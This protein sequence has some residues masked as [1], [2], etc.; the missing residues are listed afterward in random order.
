M[1]QQTKKV[2]LVIQTRD[3]RYEDIEGRCYEYPGRIQYGRQIGVGDI[4]IVSRPTKVAPDGRRIVGIGR[5][6][7]IVDGPEGRKVA[8]YDRYLAID[9]PASFDDIGGEPRQNQFITINPV[10]PAIV[11]SLLKLRGVESVDAM[12]AVAA[13]VK[14]KGAPSEYQLREELHEAVVT[15]LLGPAGGPEEEIL[16]S[17]VRDRYLV[18]KL[19]PRDGEML[20][21]EQDEMS[22][23]SD[24]GAD[25]GAAEQGAL[26]AESL[27]PA[28]FGMTFCVDSAAKEMKLLASWGHYRKT[29]S[30]V[31]LTEA[32]KPRKVWGRTPAGGEVI[33]PLTPGA[34]GPLQPDPERPEVVVQGVVRAPTP[35]D[36]VIVTAFLMNGQ[37]TPETNQDEAWL[38]Q[39]EL[40]ASA[41][42]ESPIFRRRPSGESASNDAELAALAMLYRDHV[43]FAVGHGVSIYSELAEGRRDRAVSIRTRAIPSYDVPMTEA[44]DVRDVPGFAKLE[45]DMKALA[46]L[47]KASLLRTLGVLAKEY[48][49]WIGVQAKRIEAGEVVG[50][51]HPAKEALDR[52][53]QTRS[54]LEAGIKALEQEATALDAFRFANKAMWKQRVHSIYALNRRRGKDVQL[55]DVDVPQ[56]RSWRPFQ[57]AFILLAI[58]SLTDPSHS[59]RTDIGSAVADLL[60]F[61][62]GGGKTEAYLGVAAYAMAIRRLQGVVNGLDGTRGLAVIMRYTLRLLTIQQFQRASTLLCAME[63]LRREALAAGEPRWGVT[64]FRLGL[65][66][67]QRATPNRTEDARQAIENAH[68]DAWR[69]TGSGTPAQ[70]TSCPWCG[71]EIRPGRDIK[72]R[73]FKGGVGRTLLFCSDSYGR[74]AFTPAQVPDEGLPVV[75]VDEEIYRLLPAMLI[76]TV[77]KFAQMPWKG[78]VQTLFGRVSGYCARHGFLSPDS[79]DTG[80]HNAAGQLPRTRR[81]DAPMLRPP[82][83]VIQDELHLISG[84][85]GTMVGL[86]ETAVDELATWE[87]QGKKVR[88]KVIASTATVRKA[89]EQV[90]NV[91]LRR[92]EVFPPPGLDAADN[93]FARQRPLSAEKFGRRYLGICAP[94]QSRPA[95]LIRVYVAFI[96]AAQRLRELYGAAADPWMTLV[97]Y[98]NS[99]RELGGMRRLAEDDVRTRSYRVAMGEV[100]RPGL[101]QRD[102]KVIQELTSRASSA[103]I[104]KTLDRLEV[105]FGAPGEKQDPLPIDVLLATN[106]VSVGVDVQRLGLMV[107]NG[108]PKTTAEYIQAT[109]RVG[110]RHPGL[111]CAVLNWSRPRD[112]SHYETFEHYHATFYQHV[113]ALSVTPFAPRALD[114]GLTGVL[115]SL[116]RLRGLTLNPNEAAEQ[117]STPTDQH[118][119][120]ARESVTSRTWGVT[121]ER[122][123]R[124][125]A[126]QMLQSRIDE[127]VR[128]AQRGGRVLGYKQSTGTVGLLKSPSASEWQRFTTPTS[129]REVEP[130][131][132]LILKLDLGGGAPAWCAREVDAN[133]ETGSKS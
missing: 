89:R 92:V 2:W 65:W 41:P 78:E 46:E 107:V 26:P 38:F 39:A 64:P 73:P 4:V 12:P 96:T 30:A 63:V 37:T 57:L 69:T 1:A 8:H 133:G 24:V 128:E 21:D 20:P 120:S 105:K 90:H 87:Y 101:A 27:M 40:V 34:F 50:Y 32:G 71:S 98:F 108:Q 16:G 76:A 88:P 56:N 97:G 118:A 122:E 51:E 124:D 132:S 106:M 31:H 93:F 52:C 131:V 55:E 68:G 3:S 121:E 81:E 126:D 75:V 44:P 62:T 86:Y 7:T 5:I 48:G 14:D 53:T 129:M 80:N 127:W 116:V 82:D 130:G 17:S 74:C 83:L 85:L 42:D 23:A 15:D 110:R 94:G 11:E 49:D 104:P 59:D 19:A 113:E 6:K 84:P 29:D 102:P 43:E 72:V 95:V 60:W 99:L 123:K 10:A 109:S 103:D 70:L 79:E 25:D 22:G 36:E 33:V 58:P 112:L 35:K 114:R 66:V 125:F 61:P 54:R 18:G 45:L 13:E 28:S 77:D 117:L 67:G 9:P 100:D 47:D 119:V 111:V 115:A 91:F